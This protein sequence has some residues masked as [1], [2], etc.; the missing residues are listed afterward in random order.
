[1]MV[2]I[3]SI[4]MG[5]MGLGEALNDV[6]DMKEAKLGTDRVLDLI[7]STK[8]LHIDALAE[9]G[10]KPKTV[11]GKLEFKNIHFYYPARPDQW[12]LGGPE[13]PEGFSLTIEPGQSLAFVGQSGSGYVGI[14][15]FDLM[16]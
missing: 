14:F 8:D 1:M 10:F 11:T 16:H 3:M 9:T 15:G 5:A 12:V 4:L 13:R 7:Y 2:A 6:G